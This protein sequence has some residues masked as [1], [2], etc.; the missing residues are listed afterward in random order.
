[1]S[2]T[3][4]DTRPTPGLPRRYDFPAV[5]RITFGNG[6][7]LVTVHLPGRPLVSAALVLRNGAADEPP[8]WAGATILAA[9]ALS[10]GTERWRQ[11]VAVAPLQQAQLRLGAADPGARAG[12]ACAARR[13]ST[14]TADLRGTRRSGPRGSRRR[15]SR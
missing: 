9:R 2:T 12:R 1:M 11:A 6:L 8:E 10:E 13:R 15:W 7:T 5:E 3:V 14:G 4:I